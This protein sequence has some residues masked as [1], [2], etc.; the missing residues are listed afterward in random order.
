MSLCC[1]VL[2]V[3]VGSDGLVIRDLKQSVMSEKKQYVTRI[4]VLT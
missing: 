4:L 1:V 2:C 3:R